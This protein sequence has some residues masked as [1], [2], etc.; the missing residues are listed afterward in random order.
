MATLNRME[1][2]T[3]VSGRL[4]LRITKKSD[5][6]GNHPAYTLAIMPRKHFGSFAPGKWLA[7]QPSANALRFGTLTAEESADLKEWSP[8]PAERKYV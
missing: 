1:F 4:M 7:W 3:A 5:F 2:G 6:F 8:V